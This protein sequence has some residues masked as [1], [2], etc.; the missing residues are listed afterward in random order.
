MRWLKNP[1][2]IIFVVCLFVFNLSSVHP[3]ALI[4]R[5]KPWKASTKYISLIRVWPRAFQ[6]HQLKEHFSSKAVSLV[7]G[8]FSVKEILNPNEESFILV[9][10]ILYQNARRLENEE[11]L[12]LWD[13]LWYIVYASKFKLSP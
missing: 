8:T 4:Y 6:D 3:M 2:E 13:F 10:E 1:H 11:H 12:V 5:E 9:K 7:H